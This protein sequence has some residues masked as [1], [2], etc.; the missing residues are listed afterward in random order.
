MFFFVNIIKDSQV[1]RLQKYLAY[2]NVT[3]SRKKSLKSSNILW[4]YTL[5]VLV[6][7][8]GT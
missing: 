8:R 5:L 3:R 1:E 7:Y 4:F 6:C 2:S